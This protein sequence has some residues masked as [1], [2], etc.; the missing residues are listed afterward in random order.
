MILHTLNATPSSSAFTECVRL[1]CADDAILLLGNGVY[2]ALHEGEAS[3]LLRDC[4]ASLYVLQED[5]AAAGVAKS[6]AFAFIDMAGFVGLTE[7]F[8]KQMAWY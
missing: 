4:G 2:A 5:A 6:N 8:T 7:R 3:A 1:A